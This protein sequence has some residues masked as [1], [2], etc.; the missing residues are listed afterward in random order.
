VSHGLVRARINK[1]NPERR[2]QD[3]PFR[4]AITDLTEHREK[5]L[6]RVAAGSLAAIKSRSQRRQRLMT[7]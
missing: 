4:A 6:P 2:Q 7:G 3:D 5:C 1:L